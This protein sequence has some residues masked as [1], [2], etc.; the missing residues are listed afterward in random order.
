MVQS[1]LVAALA[2]RLV[3]PQSRKFP[4]MSF[5]TAN[6]KLVPIGAPATYSRVELSGS[7]EEQIAFWDKKIDDL[8][9]R[10]VNSLQTRYSDFQNSKDWYDQAGKQIY[11]VSSHDP[12]L[13]E[14][15]TRMMTFFGNNAPVRSNVLWTVNQIQEFR[16]SYEMMQKQGSTVQQRRRVPV[17]RISDNF[18][19]FFQKMPEQ[20]NSQRQALTEAGFAVVSVQADMRRVNPTDEAL[21]E[22]AQKQVDAEQAENAALTDER[23]RRYYR[24][25]YDS[26]YSQQYHQ[27]DPELEAQSQKLFQDEIKRQKKT[28]RPDAQRK[29]LLYYYTK[30]KRK[31]EPSFA[32]D[33]GYL[34]QKAFKE[35]YGLT[36][37]D[38]PGLLYEVTKPAIIGK[39]TKALQGA[40]FVPH[41]SK[42]K[43]AVFISMPNSSAVSRLSPAVFEPIY[44]IGRQFG[45]EQ[46]V[47]VSKAFGRFP[48]Q[49]VKTLPKI[50]TAPEISPQVEGFADKLSNYY[51]AIKQGVEKAR[52]ADTGKTHQQTIDPVVLDQW[53]NALFGGA[54]TVPSNAARYNFGVHL[55]EEIRKRYT[56]KTRQPVTLSAIQAALWFYAKNVSDMLTLMKS[57][58]LPG[59]TPRQIARRSGMTLEE[60]RQFYGIPVTPGFAALASTVDTPV[61]RD[62]QNVAGYDL[63]TVFRQTM[64]NATLPW[65][66]RGRVPTLEPEKEKILADQIQGTVLR[67]GQDNGLYSP[68]LQ[69]LGMDLHTLAPGPNGFGISVPTYKPHKLQND[70]SVADAFLASTAYVLG[71]R[72]ISKLYA[73]QIDPTLPEKN[74]RVLQAT[75]ENPLLPEQILAVSRTL[76]GLDFIWEGS[77]VLK[78]VNLDPA[79]TPRFTP[80]AEKVKHLLEHANAVPFTLQ[81]LRAQIIQH[82]PQRVKSQYEKLYG[83]AKPDNLHAYLKSGQYYLDVLHQYGR[84]D[85]VPHLESMKKSIDNLYRGQKIKRASGANSGSQPMYCMLIVGFA[86]G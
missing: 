53:M 43:R 6:Q 26:L 44:A 68:I 78:I 4:W 37:D 77:Q 72:D 61:L 18:E 19:L 64:A 52:A 70:L 10:L 33:E 56:A 51:H 31:Q 55:M 45:L 42:T 13:Q 11:E 39:F 86:K 50:M 57:K 65:I 30:L 25:R 80:F 62:F 48:T 12:K 60:A 41:L 67:R 17:N 2:S 34:T 15:L 28:Y 81:P 27:L 66:D 3:A 59:L 75:F 21:W 74:Q 29:R 82:S 84:Q 63:Q 36:N 73:V 35:G 71:Y 5:R 1:N 40:G 9:N 47:D 49:V 24:D 7:P 14:Y 85:V 79:P 46:P 83:K 69:A 58:R 32:L 23:L 76:D 8:I 54:Q 38:F 16:R 22:E 20:W